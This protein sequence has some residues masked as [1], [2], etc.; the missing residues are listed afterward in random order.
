[1]SNFVEELVSEYYRTK[2]YFVM[3]NYWFPTVGKRKRT[4]RGKRQS[5]DAQSWS[6]LDVT[7]INDKELVLIQVKAIVNE[8]KVANKIIDYFDKVDS[9]L[10]SGNVKWWK[11]KKRIKKMLVYENYS[12]PKYTNKISEQGIEVVKFRKFYEELLQHIQKKKGSKEENPIMR[13]IYY[14]NNNSLV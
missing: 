11:H 3:T 12:I 4:Q 7:A 5:F 2:G 8:M 14:L 13:F 9:F 10:K 6:D 1:M